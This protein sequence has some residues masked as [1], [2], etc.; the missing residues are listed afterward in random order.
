[1]YNDSIPWQ[2][3]ITTSEN[4]TTTELPLLNFTIK[5]LSFLIFPLLKKSELKRILFGIFSGISVPDAS[6]LDTQKHPIFTRTFSFT[7]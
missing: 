6:F 2:L 4:E 1:M 3:D 7:L 5:G